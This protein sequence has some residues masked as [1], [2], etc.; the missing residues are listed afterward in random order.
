MPAYQD[1]SV[2]KPQ[3]PIRETLLGY[4][5]K[6]H[7]LQLSRQSTLILQTNPLPG[8]TEWSVKKVLKIACR[9]IQINHWKKQFG[10]VVQSL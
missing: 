5:I 10:E 3:G 8:L 6:A 7:K 4:T 1:R 9:N 2:T